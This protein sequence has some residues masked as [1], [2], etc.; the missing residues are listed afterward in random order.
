D[1]GAARTVIAMFDTSLSMQWEKL[2]RSFQALEAVLRSLRPADRF[3]LLLFNTDATLLAPAPVPADTAG[4]EKALAFVR[5]GRLRGGT[6]LQQALGLAL[7]QSQLGAG[8]RYI[9]LLGDASGTR[10]TIANAT[11]AAWYAKRRGAIAA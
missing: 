11:L 7:D 1:G 5:A 4:V 6:D 2:E 3:N 10:G 9:V 8:D